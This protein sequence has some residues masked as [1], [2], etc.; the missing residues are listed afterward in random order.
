VCLAAALV[1][2]DR[3]PSTSRR[4]RRRGLVTIWSIDVGRQRLAFDADPARSARQL[5]DSDD[6][7]R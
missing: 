6:V 5:V 7:T 3:S 2:A 1:A 4:R